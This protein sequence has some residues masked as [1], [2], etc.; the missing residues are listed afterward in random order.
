MPI[1]PRQIAAIQMQLEVL[2]RENKEEPDLRKELK[3]AH[4]AIIEIGN[5]AQR[6]GL[7]LQLPP[8]YKP[9]PGLGGSGTSKPK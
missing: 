7:Y 5:A 8:D 9:P 2:M 1:D 4:D 3:K 6:R